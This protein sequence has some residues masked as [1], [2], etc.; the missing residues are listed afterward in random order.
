M[1]GARF[2]HDRLELAGWQ[3]EIAD[4][5]KV[6][7]LAPLACKTDRID[8]WRSSASKV[9][10]YVGNEHQFQTLVPRL[11]GHTDEAQRRKP[12]ARPPKS[13][14]DEERFFAEMQTRAGE[15]VDLHTRQAAKR[16]SRVTIQAVCDLIDT[17][18]NSAFDYTEWPEVS[19]HVTGAQIT[20]PAARLDFELAAM[21][22][23]F[24]RSI[25]GGEQRR[26][27][28]E[29]ARARALAAARRGRP[30]PIADKPQGQPRPPL[31]RS[32]ASDRHRRPLSLWECSA[33]PPSL[34]EMRAPGAMTAS[35]RPAEVGDV[36]RTSE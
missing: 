10:Q 3:V 19:A 18:C 30:R 12:S 27:L 9:K 2:V 29:P 16:N 24:A 4:A 20:P 34:L 35:R 28:L 21:S 26:R 31:D 22:Q 8:A 13:S 6:K 17:G 7:G 36:E 33:S 1:N 15:T 25:E 23:E 5:E 11:V 14:W 32:P